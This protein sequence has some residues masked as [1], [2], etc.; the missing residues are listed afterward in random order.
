[1]H[2]KRFDPLL[3]GIREICEMCFFFHPCIWWAGAQLEAAMEES[4]DRA[5]VK[6]SE[7]AREYAKILFRI[8]ADL[9]IRRRLAPDVGLSAMRT[10]I[11]RRISALLRNPAEL[12][13]R[14]RLIAWAGIICIAALILVPGIEIANATAQSQ[15]ERYVASL[16]DE[17]QTSAKESVLVF[18]PSSEKWQ[19]WLEGMDGSGQMRSPTRIVARSPWSLERRLGVDLTAWPK[20][21]DAQGHVNIPAGQEIGLVVMG[22]FWDDL[23]PLA[24]L[25]EDA[26]HAIC[27]SNVGYAHVVNARPF[28]WL[29]DSDM[30]YV[31]RQKR[32][33]ILQCANTELGDEALVHIAQM[34][35]LI[36]LNL[37]GTKITDEGL[38]LLTG[39]ENLRYLNLRGTL[40]GD[41]GMTHVAKLSN[42]EVLLLDRTYVADPGMSHLA[43]LQNLEMLGLDHTKVGNMGLEHLKGLKSLRCLGLNFTLVT[44]EGIAHLRGL[45]KLQEVVCSNTLVTDDGLNQLAGLPEFRHDLA[46]YSL[47]RVGVLLSHFTATGPNWKG[48]PYEYDHSIT[49]AQKLQDMGFDVYAVIDPGTRHLGELPAV[50]AEL[51]LDD[52][53]IEGRIGRELRSLDAIVSPQNPNIRDEVLGGI[54]DAVKHGTGFVNFSTFGTVTPTYESEAVQELFGIRDPEYYFHF[55]P[56][57]TKVVGDHPILHPLE[58]GDV[59]H[60]MWVNGMSGQIDGTALLSAPEGVPEDFVPLYV[61]TLGEGRVVN[62]QCHL[63][64]EPTPP[65]TFDGMFARCILWVAGWELETN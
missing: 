9:R 3:Q 40:V 55:K 1:M 62:Y 6:D 52:Y 54:L 46:Y 7:Q 5:L 14:H 20:L 38:S 42:L 33:Q 36:E 32:L 35:Q 50:L 63:E 16:A 11:G 19:E 44:D 48:N 13:R 30:E 53:V 21:A 29:R 24:S 2:W 56:F 37:E 10:Q 45:E 17:P 51:G 23:S 8:L 60:I 34:P 65:H 43:G 49:L 27:V 39:L 4:C 64:P 61:R 47:V 28:T 25:P 12:D 59:F 58:D 22:K 15:F 31:A 57:D 26:L 18:P 41:A